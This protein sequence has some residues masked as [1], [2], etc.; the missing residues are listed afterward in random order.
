MPTG[1][2]ADKDVRRHMSHQQGSHVKVN[3][4]PKVVD[5]LWSSRTSFHRSGA[6]KRGGPTRFWAPTTTP[7]DAWRCTTPMNVARLSRIV[8]HRHAATSRCATLLWQDLLGCCMATSAR[9]GAPGIQRKERAGVLIHS[10]NAVQCDMGMRH[11]VVIGVAR[12]GCLLWAA[13]IN[14]WKL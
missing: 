3:P 9:L 7:Y 6:P 4:F 8:V 1:N 2:L 10:F 5:V 13:K 14:C 11:A 12:H